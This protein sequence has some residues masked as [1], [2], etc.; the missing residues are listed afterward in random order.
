MHAGA[1]GDESAK[2]VALNLQATQLRI[3]RC[4]ARSPEGGRVTGI[5]PEYALVEEGQIVVQDFVGF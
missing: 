2:V 3:A 5:H 4:I 1:L